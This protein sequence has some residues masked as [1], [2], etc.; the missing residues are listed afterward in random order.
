LSF[1]SFRKAGKVK[2]LTALSPNHYSIFTA[3]KVDLSK[4]KAAL[5]SVLITCILS[6]HASAVQYVEDF[7]YEKPAQNDFT[8]GIFQHSIELKPPLDYLFWDIT[9]DSVP[10]PPDCNFLLL[11]PAIDEITFALDP[12]EYVDY[13]SIEFCDYAN[14]TI[15]EVTGTLGRYTSEIFWNG[16]TWESAD[17]CGQPLG[18]ITMIRLISSE[19]GFDNLTINVVP[20]PST[21]LL[22]S[23]GAAF[24]RKRR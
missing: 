18:Q 14:S 5:F 2:K 15:F 4:L 13:A 23:L 24:L 9:D 1:Q 3:K 7:E 11:A 21:L 20:E 10:P 19:G 22:L 12:G 17:T 8:N 6:S 16:G